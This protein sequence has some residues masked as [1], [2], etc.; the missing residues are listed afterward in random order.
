MNR[1][2]TIRKC[3]SYNLE[4]VIRVVADVYENSEGPDLTGKRVLIKP[5]ILTDSPP[6]K[7]ICTH[8]VVVE[9]VIRY[10]QS[11]GAEVVVGDSPSVHI[12]NFRPVKCGIEDVCR[13]T[14]V[15]W[16][17]FKEKPVEVNLRNGKKIKVASVIRD[18]DLIISLPKFKNHELAYFTGAIKNTLGVVPGFIK[19]KQH[20]LYQ[21]RMAFSRFLVD[22]NEAVLPDYF[23]MDAIYGME[24]PGP[25]NGFPKKIG[26]L[27]GSANPLALDIIASTIAGY[28]P[29]DIPTNRIGLSRGEWL[30]SVDEIV[31]DGPSLDSLVLKDFLKV[32]VTRM[33]NISLQFLIR[34]V[35]FLRKLERRPVFL[36]DRCT[37]CLKCVKICPV[38]AIS[39]HP[40]KKNHIVLTDKKCIRCYCC[41]E[42]CTDS[43]IEIRRK[44]FGV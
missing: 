40:S 4:E 39:P 14:G 42:V 28:K 12:G 22:L 6:E 38:N 33:E 37:G 7:S 18:V 3:D 8:P 36:H 5:N 23:L 11:K 19:G 24:G 41:S 31:Y 27:I 17:D 29:I 35:K 30:L 1:K 43:A 26:L 34:R 20:A 44:L 2:V 9:A 16:V 15:Q 32:P 10:I 13:R 21:N 25:A